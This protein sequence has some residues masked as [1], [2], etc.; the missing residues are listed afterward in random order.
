MPPFLGGLT[1]VSG[2]SFFELTAFDLDISFEVS[3]FG[4]S[5]FG[6]VDGGVWISFG[7]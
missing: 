2:A 3:S 6:P 5:S 7:S 1:L 4:F